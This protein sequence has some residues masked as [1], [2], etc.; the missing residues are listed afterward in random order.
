M[1]T[2]QQARR[3]ADQHADDLSTYPNV[4]GIGTQPVEEA[5]TG[6]DG[7]HAVAVYVSH[8]VPSDRLDAREQLPM[9]VEVATAGATTTV[10][11]VVVEVGTFD[12]EADGD[13]GTTDTFTTE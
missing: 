7:G 1:A 4:V 3:A 8:K 6:A 11:V 5:S 13:A 9:S 12:P 10:P 2:P